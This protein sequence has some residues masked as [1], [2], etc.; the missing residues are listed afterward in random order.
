MR[1]EEL[2]SGDSGSGKRNLLKVPCSIE[3]PCFSTSPSAYL[4]LPFIS[5]TGTAALRFLR[6][7]FNISC[8][9]SNQ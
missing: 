3:V 9:S 5:P 7:K 2:L 8:K 4:S 6:R 1:I